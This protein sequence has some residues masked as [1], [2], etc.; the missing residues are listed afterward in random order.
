[1]KIFDA[2]IS[3]SLFS[4]SGGGGGGGDSDFSTAQITVANG[5]PAM[6]MASFWDF[7]E[8]GVVGSV[9]SNTESSS[10]YR[11]ILYKGKAYVNVSASIVSISGNASIDEMTGMLA[12]TGDCTI[13]IA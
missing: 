9:G 8:Y 11:V 2:L 1:M 12:V 6:D 10:P 4:G 7:P 3:K 13:T 5:D